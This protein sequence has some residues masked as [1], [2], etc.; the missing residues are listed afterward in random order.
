MKEFG[1][2]ISGMLLTDGILGEKTVS[3]PLYS[4]QS[5]HMDGLGLKRELCGEE[6][7]K[8]LSS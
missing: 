5:P 3:V 2:G 4:P 8:K 6:P 7:I 1:R